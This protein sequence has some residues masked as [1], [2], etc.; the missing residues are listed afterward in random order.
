MGDFMVANDL[1][2]PG[3]SGHA[4]TWTDNKMHGVG[5]KVKNLTRL[6]LDHCP[7]LCSIQEGGRK[8][9]SHWIK[10]EDVWTT[11]PRAWQLVQDKWKLKEELDG[12]IRIL[13]ELECSPAG[14]SKAQT[15]SLRYK[16]Q[17]LKSTLARIMTW[18]SQR[19]KVRW[20]EEG[21]GNTRFFRTMASARLRSNF[22]EQ[23]NY[24]NG[25][26]ATK[27]TEILRLVYGF[28][29]Q[30]WNENPITEAGWPSLN[31]Q[32]ACK[33]RFAGLLVGEVTHDE[34]WLAVRSLGSNRALGR[35]V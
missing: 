3:F 34:I 5:L 10:F 12:E 8:T 17:L 7:I 26:P 2:D 30:K 15:E 24:P 29:A 22:I 6:A 25:Q 16:V 23:L 20:I 35:M 32:L 9:Y 28:F 18:W 11:F 13:Q 31:S 33:D 4:F 19:A 27:Q 21:D 1:V 14:L